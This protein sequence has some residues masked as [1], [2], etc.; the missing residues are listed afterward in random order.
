MPP[1]IL[2]FT[3]SALPACNAPEIANWRAY[4]APNRDR[5][6]LPVRDGVKRLS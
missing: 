2:D 1:I 3:V 4:C 6:F 5:V